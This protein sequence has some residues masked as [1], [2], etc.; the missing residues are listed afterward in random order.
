MLFQDPGLVPVVHLIMSLGHGSAL[1]AEE[2]GK[3]S[4]AFALGMEGERWRENENNAA[5]RCWTF[6][7][8]TYILYIYIYIYI[9]MYY[10]Y[11]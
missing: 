10:V 3:P 8:N 7:W 1:D 2:T 6:M 11:I 5:Q 9:Y 4:L